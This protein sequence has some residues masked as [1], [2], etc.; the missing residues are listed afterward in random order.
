LTPFIRP[1]RWTRLLWTY[2]LPVVPLVV[3]FDGVVS[4]LRSYTVAE[5]QAFAAELSGSG[6]EWDVGETAAQGWRAPVTY[7]IGYPAVE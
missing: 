4:V 6:Y 1:F 3:V 2:L 7:L 5:L